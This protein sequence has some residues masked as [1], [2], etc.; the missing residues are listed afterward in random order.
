MGTSVGF[1]QTW[2]PLKNTLCPLLI[3]EADS[4]SRI[5]QCIELDII[6]RASILDVKWIQDTKSA[7]AIS[8][9]GSIGILPAFWTS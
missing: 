7:F 9:Q 2:P 4:I 5:P 3:S 8:N 1:E 6:N